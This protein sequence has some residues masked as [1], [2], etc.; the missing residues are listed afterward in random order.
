MRNNQSAALL[1]LALVV[2]P[3][4]ATG[5]DFYIDP[6]NGSPDGDGSAAR[7]WRTLQEVLAA[8]L[9]QG[10]QCETLP[11][12][13]DCNM[14]VRNPNAPV[15]PGD[16]LK[17]RTGY[18]GAITIQDA[19]LERPITV[20]ADAGHQ[21]AFS[22][23]RCLGAGN[24][25][26]RGISISPSH[27]EPYAPVA[28]LVMLENHNFRGPC[29]EVT[30]EDCVLFSVWDTSLWTIDDWN[31]LPASGIQI[32]GPDNLVRHN[33][34]RNVNFG[35]SASGPRARVIGN[36]VENFAGDGLRGLGDEDLFE[37]NLVMNC[38]DVNANHDDG[39]Q[40]WSVGPGGVGTGEVRGVVLRRNTIINY[41]DPDQ[42]FRGT[43]QGIG[44]FDG[45][46]TD[47]I[48]ENNVI[49]TDHWHG[50]TFL[51]ARNVR[52][53]N[54]TVVDI[55]Q[56]SPG[57]AWIRIDDHK[58]G[59][60]SENCLVRNN[61]GMSF[62]LGPETAADHNLTIDFAWA[63]QHFVDYAGRDVH[64]RAGSPAIDQ[65]N[66][67]LAP[68]VDRDGVARPQGDGF[69]IGAYEWT[70]EPRPDGGAD[71]SDAGTDA[72]MDAGVDAGGDTGQMDAGGDAGADDGSSPEDGGD[73]SPSDG[74][75]GD[76]GD[77]A[78]GDRPG[79]RVSG[80]SC[81]CGNSPSSS[82]ASGFA[83]LPFL[84]RL[85]PRPQR[86]RTAPPVQ[87]TVG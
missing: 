21:P 62:Q 46:Y 13:A 28:N 45:F 4:T 51:G 31:N 11:W 33:Y 84:L 71:G 17:L 10:R 12:Q 56:V 81:G 22:S 52:I 42:P 75:S 18:H 26:F 37:D 59:T 20:E 25:V 7:P 67:D 44:C 3:L 48:V 23:L 80:T 47:W 86:R 14:T 69:D 32:Q 60:P 50:I 73:A 6:Q 79:G 19:Y 8:G 35:I 72:G 63:S 55:N 68:A 24:W 64:L 43:L 34:L 74:V 30:V 27:A 65:G 54:N 29:R 49:I 87:G 61:L 16:T 78:Q 5:R 15:K 40:S 36:V 57:P 83:L 2:S 70:T 39:F 9:I 53:V 66:P 38:Y 41:V 82:L 58:D 77:G 1:S 76:G 85:R